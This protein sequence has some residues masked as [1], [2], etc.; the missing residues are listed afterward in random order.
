VCSNS[1]L[2]HK[3]QCNIGR[4]LVLLPCTYVLLSK[5]ILLKLCIEDSKCYLFFFFFGL[6]TY[7]HTSLVCTHLIN[8]Y[9]LSST[10]LEIREKQFL[11]E[12]KGVWGR[13]GVGWKG[14]GG[15]KGG[16]MTQSLYAHMSKGKEKKINA[17]QICNV[18]R[19][20]FS[21]S[22]ECVSTSILRPL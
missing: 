9:T 2:S 17:M 8:V 5:L 20:D 4:F 6:P 7:A 10:K 13:E 12:S 15:G 1:L 14:G 21:I 22:Q 3:N 18:F 19:V 16:V 11:P